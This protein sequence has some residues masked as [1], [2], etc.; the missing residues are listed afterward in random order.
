V[1]VG[2]AADYAVYLEIARANRVVFDSRVVVRY[3]QHDSN[4]SRDP[5]K[6][7]RA[8]LAVLRREEPRVPARYQRQFKAGRRDWCTF[9]GE[10]IIQQLRSDL[11]H[12]RLGHEQFDRALLLLR[13]CR[14]L[15]FTHLTRKLRRVL[16]GQ[17]PT[18][19][20]PG[21]FAPVPPGSSTDLR[22]DGVEP[23]AYGHGNPRP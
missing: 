19:I 8:T 18:E 12:R 2:P 9:Y 5:S 20:E 4:M 6:M 13:D 22:F 21:R 11:R 23:P 17:A 10:Q 16:T 1:D 15:A 7:L 3:R 14:S